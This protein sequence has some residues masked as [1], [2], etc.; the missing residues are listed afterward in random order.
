MVREMWRRWPAWLRSASFLIALATAVLVFRLTTPFFRPA[1]LLIEIDAGQGEVWVGDYRLTSKTLVKGSTGNLDKARKEGR[2]WLPSRRLS[3]GRTSFRLPM[4]RQP[5]APFWDWYLHEVT[6]GQFGSAPGV[7]RNRGSF[8][9][10]RAGDEEWC[11]CAYKDGNWDSEVLVILAKGGSL[12]TDPMER[13]VS[14]VP[15]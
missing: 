2:E 8:A 11:V 1:V 10:I 13:I 5:G 7:F 14:F 3:S 6:F 4:H 12:R 15:R 9:G